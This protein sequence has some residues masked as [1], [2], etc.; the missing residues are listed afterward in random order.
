MGLLPWIGRPSPFLDGLQD[1]P[2]LV[3][4][5]PPGP[6][7][8]ARTRHRDGEHSPIF[9]Q[10]PDPGHPGLAQDDLP[11]LDAA[12]PEGPGAGQEV[13]PPHPEEA[14]VQAILQ[15]RPVPGEVPVPGHQRGVVVGAE[16]I[17]VLLDKATL[18][19]SADLGHGW[20][21]AVG[22]DVIGHPGVPGGPC[23]A[24]ADGVEAGRPR[25]GPS[26]GARRQ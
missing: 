12:R 1:P 7:R 15:F 20:H 4:P 25:P 11:E 14:M 13:V 9:L 3:K 18:H 5:G 22:E 10:I 26:A 2:A 21:L 23:D 16:I 6:E 17:P 8:S 19:D 24:A